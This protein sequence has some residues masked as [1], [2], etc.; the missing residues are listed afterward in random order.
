[1]STTPKPTIYR[2]FLLT[3]WQEEQDQW[4]FLLEDPRSGKRQGFS[5]L[6]SLVGGLQDVMDGNVTSTDLDSAE[7]SGR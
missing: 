4:R 1:M 2:I 3:V 6:E 7:S 5:E